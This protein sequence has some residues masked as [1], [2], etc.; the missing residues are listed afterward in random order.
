MELVRENKL[1]MNCLKP[2]H[3]VKH[4]TLKQA[5]KKCQQNHHTLLHQEGKKENGASG[6]E[7]PG[8]SSTPSP[9]AS[10]VEF[11]AS[12]QALRASGQDQVLLM[13]CQ[14]MVMSP[15]GIACRARA[16]L[17]TG[18]SLSFITYM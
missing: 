6:K 18:S 16:F 1:Y 8:P 7:T 10:P 13:M 9:A 11:V 14:V 5:C 17:D 3:F 15:G 2:G 12:T 4:C